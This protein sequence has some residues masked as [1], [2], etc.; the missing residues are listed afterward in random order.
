M[1]AKQQEN[2]FKKMQ[3]AK[4]KWIEFIDF[5]FLSDD[6]KLSYKYLIEERFAR[7]ISGK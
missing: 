6:F 4:D 7:L 1:E 3:K 5:S 2:I